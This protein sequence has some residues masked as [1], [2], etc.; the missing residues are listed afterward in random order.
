MTQ[1]NIDTLFDRRLEFPDSEALSRYR[2]LVG[3]DKHK[4]VVE[5][6]LSVL[7]IPSSLDKWKNKYYPNNEVNLDFVYRRPPLVIFEG[8]VGTGKTELSETIGA[9]VAKTLNAEITLYPLSLGSRGEGRVGQM[10]QL[11]SQA[12]G[13]I[14]E[15]AQRIRGGNSSSGIILLL[16]EADAIAQSRESNQMHHEDKS[17]VNALIKGIDRIAESQLPVVIILC[18]NR[19]SSLDPAVKRRACEVFRFTRPDTELRKLILK[20][21]F[22]GFG[23]SDVDINNLADLTGPVNDNIGFT[24]SDISQRF[25]PSVIMECYPDKPVSIDTAKNVLERINPTP[26]FVEEK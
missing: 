4:I 24:C 3:I 7:L 5:K 22:D 1:S 17:G 8:D 2:Q 10:T 20:N 21:G 16:D 13:H 6:L 23:F 11:L 15:K 19:A 9:Q 14:Y 18:T 26:Q 25:I 12:F